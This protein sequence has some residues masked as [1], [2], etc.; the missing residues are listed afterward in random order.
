MEGDKLAHAGLPPSIFRLLPFSNSQQRNTLLMKPIKSSEHPAPTSSLLSL[1]LSP[2]RVIGQL[3]HRLVRPVHEQVTD[4]PIS[5]EQPSTIPAHLMWDGVPLQ[6]P[7]DGVG[8][9]FHRRYWVDIARPKASAKA[10]MEVVQRDVATFAPAELAK[11]EKVTGSPDAMALGD[12]YAIEMLGPWNGAVRV[13]EVTPT[14]FCLVTLEGHPEAGQI[15][16][17]AEPAPSAPSSL[18]FSILSWARSRDML[19]S[20][21]YHEGQVGKVVQQNVWVTF[22]ERVVEASGGELIG[23]PMVLTEERTFKGEVIPVG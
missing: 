4:Q 7:A 3:L 20:L 1:A 12:E 8:P 6:L 14:S 19:V 10:L 5:G 18:R 23:E 9:L 17:R 13:I 16:F 22:C 15:C 21:S 11:F 2:L